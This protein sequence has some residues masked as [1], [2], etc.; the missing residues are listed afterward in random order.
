MNKV[1]KVSLNGKWTLIQ[2]EKDLE[3]LQKHIQTIEKSILEYEKFSKIFE[4]RNKELQTAKNLENEMAIKKAEINKEIQ[5]LETQI[6]EKREEIKKK[7]DLKNKTE[8]LR[9]IEYWVSKKFLDLILFTEKQVMITL[10]EEFSRL[11][12][13]GRLFR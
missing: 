6:K 11:F 4:H 2:K 1:E 12:S 9:E 13:K 7:Q 10:K 3:N 8:K 5:F